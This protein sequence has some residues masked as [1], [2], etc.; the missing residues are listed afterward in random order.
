MALKDITALYEM[1]DNKSLQLDSNL[2]FFLDMIT[3][4][5]SGAYAYYK[6]SRDLPNS[7]TF[8]PAARVG[9]ALTGRTSCHDALMISWVTSGDSSLMSDRIN[10][11]L[12]DQLARLKREKQIGR[13]FIQENYPHLIDSSGEFIFKPI[14]G[15]KKFLNGS[16]V[17]FMKT[18]YDVY[19]TFSKYEHYG[20]MYEIIQSSSHDKF[21]GYYI[22]SLVAMLI[23]MKSCLSALSF[24]LPDRAEK[25][26]TALKQLLEDLTYD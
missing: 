24:L 20:I 18:V 6:L 11:I 4:A 3:R 15:A 23:N 16:D 19:D 8:P 17:E 13:E 10:M 14:S 12:T 2:N 21:Y 7:L 26:R 5:Y 9:F 22:H 25:S 1:R